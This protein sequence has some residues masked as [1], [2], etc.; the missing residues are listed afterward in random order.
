MA[1]EFQPGDVVVCV[2]PDTPAA[3]GWRGPSQLRLGA[4]YRVATVFVDSW[5][6]CCTVRGVV[7]DTVNGGFLCRRFRK[8]PKADDSF[9][10][11]MRKL[12]RAHDRVPA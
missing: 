3:I 5:G 4:S 2:D 12:K 7:A 11:Q 1:D 8:L 6:L 10:E 9:I